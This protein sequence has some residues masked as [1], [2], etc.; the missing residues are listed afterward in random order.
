M[1]LSGSREASQ[2]QETASQ[3][4]VGGIQSGGQLTVT[5]TGDT[6]LEG[7]RIR[8]AGD[9]TVNAGGNLSVEA[10]R[11]ERSSS[12]SANSVGGEVEVGKG[13][14][15]KP[16]V[17]GGKLDA[18]VSQASNSSSNATGAS[19]ES[20]GAVQL[21][22]GKTATLEGTDVTAQKGVSVDGA[23]VDLKVAQSSQSSEAFSADLSLA[24]SR[25][26]ARSPTVVARALKAA[27]PMA[28]E[29]SRWSVVR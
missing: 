4:V 17:E 16:Q 29:T 21:S 23:K 22:A 24:A 10:A 2:S 19:M 7:T 25:V 3:A 27:R 13:K 15:G 6:R 20:G 1:T 9:T 28:M 26:T 8:S 5:T 11:D 12:A 14:K 18:S